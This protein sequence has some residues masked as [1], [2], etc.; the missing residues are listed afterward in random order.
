MISQRLAACVNIVKNV[1]SIYEWKDKVEIDEEA[2]LIIKSN[3]D[4]TEDL[5]EFI[6]KHHPYDCPEVVTLRV[7]IRQNCSLNIEAPILTNL[8]PIQQVDSGS[9]AYLNWIHETVNKQPIKP[10][11]HDE[12]KK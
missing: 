11:S 5:T 1:E 2:M 9:K 7:C 10:S 12:E 3:S 8:T 6:E 4:K